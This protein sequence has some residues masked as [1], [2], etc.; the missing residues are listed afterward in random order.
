[1]HSCCFKEKYRKEDKKVAQD[2]PLAGQR[3]G[4]HQKRKRLLPVNQSKL[5]E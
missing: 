5:K 4:Q 3:E 1:M 2:N